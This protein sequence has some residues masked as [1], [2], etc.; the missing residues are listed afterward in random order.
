MFSTANRV[1]H[2]PGAEIL[3]GS[4]LRE[5]LLDR[6]FEAVADCVEES[7]I[8]SLFHAESVCGRGG[9]RV[10]ALRDMPFADPAWFTFL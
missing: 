3:S 9:N 5:D 6:V 2:A 1:S 4:F 8:S 7:V 10:S